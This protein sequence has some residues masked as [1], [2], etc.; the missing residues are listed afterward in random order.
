MI[1][2]QIQL[3]QNE[4]ILFVDYNDL[5][6]FRKILRFYIE[7]NFMSEMQIEILLITGIIVMV[8]IIKVCR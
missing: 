1:D 7:G 2:L 4:S 6:I 5:K 3:L 8:T